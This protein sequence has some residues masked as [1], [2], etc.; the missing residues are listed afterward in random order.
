METPRRRLHVGDP[1]LRPKAVDADA[2][3]QSRLAPIPLILALLTI[4]IA[5]V[6]LKGTYFGLR[7]KAVGKNPNRYLL[8]IPTWQHMMLSFA[9]CGAFAGLAGPSR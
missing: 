9:I 3:C 1:P 7:L 4:L 8:G 6:L 2:L 5:F